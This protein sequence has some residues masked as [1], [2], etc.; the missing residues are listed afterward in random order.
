MKTIARTF[1]HIS[2]TE[3]KP[4]ETSGFERFI[5]YYVIFLLVIIFSTSSSLLLK[6]DLFYVYLGGAQNPLVFLLAIWLT[7]KALKK[8]RT[9]PHSEAD[10]SLLLIVLLTVISLLFSSNPV[11]VTNAGFPQN[12]EGSLEYFI[13]TLLFIGF[14]YLTLDTMRRRENLV[15]ILYIILSTGFIVVT[16]NIY[17]LVNN[18]FCTFGI[19]ER[20]P[21]WTGKIPLG[22]YNSFLICFFLGFLF[23]R[24][25]SPSKLINM[26]IWL[27]LVGAGVSLFFSFSRGSWITLILILILVGIMK[28]GRY[29]FYSLLIIALVFTMVFPDIV[30]DVSLAVYNINSGNVDDRIYIWKSA[31]DMIRDHPLVGVGPGTF[32]VNYLNRYQL[33]ES[34][35]WNASYHAHNVFL[36]VAAEQGYLGLG[37]FLMFWGIVFRRLILNFRLNNRSDD[38][39]KGFS[40]GILFCF[41]N[42]FLWSLTNTSLGSTTRSFFNINMIIWFF[43]A[44]TFIIPKIIETTTPVEKAGVDGTIP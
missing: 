35:R 2:V 6:T 15:H 16:F 12:V 36:H 23:Y 24:W 44:L 40:C 1:A 43:A 18:E 4:D 33:V 34:S 10:R 41:I 30:G 11:E 39:L 17:Y 13:I 9:F 26:L 7:W 3:N 32:N 38:F 27:L 21:F 5:Y 31:L 19:L 37:A 20:Y 42:Y 14:F 28:L 8:F 29:F 22:F 25:R